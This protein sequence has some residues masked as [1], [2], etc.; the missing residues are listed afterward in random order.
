[1]AATVDMVATVDMA[2][3]TVDMAAFII[4]T[5][6]RRHHQVRRSSVWQYCMDNL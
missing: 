5:I 1:M 4:I 2:A 3:A 6:Q